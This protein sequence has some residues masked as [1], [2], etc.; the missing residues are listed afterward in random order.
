[1]EV[2]ILG[3]GCPKCKRAEELT[4]E[5]AKEAGIEISVTKVTDIKQI[6]EYNI[7]S[8]PGLVINESLKSSGRIPR[9]EE[10]VAWLR[11]AESQPK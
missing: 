7:L 11:Q 3:T 5:A 4:R 2:K 6:M 9:K 10:I 1:M 8:T